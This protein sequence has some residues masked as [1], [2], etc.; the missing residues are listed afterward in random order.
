VGVG[1]GVGVGV[2]VLTGVAVGLGT[3]VATATAVG[4]GVGTP[5][6]TAAGWP[7]TIGSWLGGVSALGL[8]LAPPPCPLLG[9]LFEDARAA[10]L[11]LCPPAV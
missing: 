4:A 2:G 8:G 10:E 5:A 3:G 11:P 1:T 9:R 6:A 7:V